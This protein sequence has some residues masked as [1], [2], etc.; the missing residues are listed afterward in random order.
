M[1]NLNQQNS[2]LYICIPQLNTLGQPLE[3]PML[4]TIP[5]HCLCRDQVLAWPLA[6]ISIKQLLHRLVRP[7]FEAKHRDHCGKG[8]PVW[9]SPLA[10]LLCLCSPSHIPS[11]SPP[12]T[13]K[14]LQE[15]QGS[16]IQG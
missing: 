1:L 10:L 5:K 8:D 12:H 11:R 7:Y 16:S 15:A 3:G 2:Q 13:S 6:K 4:E 9:Q 14:A